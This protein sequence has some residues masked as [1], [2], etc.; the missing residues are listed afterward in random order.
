MKI[1]AHRGCHSPSRPENTLAAFQHAV[2]QGVDGIETDI[3]AAADGTAILFHDRLAPDGVPV[4]S[5]TRAQLSAR[6]GYDVPTLEEALLQGWDVE[7]DLEIKN[8][9]GLAAAIPV[10]SSPRPIRAFVSSFDH[11][12]VLAAVDVLA[13]S[14]GLLIYHAPLDAARLGPPP[15]SIPYLIWDFETI[16]ESNAQM[17]SDLGFRNMVYGPITEEEHRITRELGVETVITDFVEYYA[18]S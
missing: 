10:L 6:V 13:L 17:A 9:G 12:V 1:F 14:G 11:Q 15:P 8:R 5:L 18:R 2:D 3:R 7:W 4:S 16:T